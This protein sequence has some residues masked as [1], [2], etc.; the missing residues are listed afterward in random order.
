VTPASSTTAPPRFIA[1][2]LPQFHPIPEND[3]WW[4]KGF[5]EWTNVS[6]AK[7][8]F[9]GH[10]QPHVPSD[11][12]FYDLRVPEARE[13]QAALARQYGIHGFMYYHYWFG[14]KRLIERP[15]EEVLKTGQPDF[16]FCLCWANEPW[17]RSWLGDTR[18]ILMPQ[19]YSP[20]DF[21]RHAE[22]L[23]RAFADKRYIRVNGRP[24]FV[25]YRHSH[26]PRDYSGID[27]LRETLAKQGSP[28]PYLVAVDSHD[29]NFDYRTV[30]FDH[31][32]AF[33]PALGA[34]AGSLS[35]HPFSPRRVVRN[36]R[37]G[38]A[39]PSLKIYHY[40]EAMEMMERAAPSH[41]RIPC[42]LV[43]WDN[44]ARRGEKAVVFLESNPKTFGKVLERRL[45]QWAGS[46][47]STDLFFLNAW[48]EWAEGNHL[49]PDQKYGLGYLETLRKVRNRVGARHGWPEIASAAAS[50]PLPF[51][52]QDPALRAM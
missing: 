6:R 46:S 28:D 16:P 40:E 3:T 41:S 32:L 12:G 35:N 43:A 4:G 51:H 36:L 30:G 27:I 2:Y 15:F 37:A 49:E 13:A 25:I 21:R 24:L 23:G 1:H 19:E 18:E 34:V 48:N 22:W 26:M 5:T 10:Y 31:V 39:S 8:L 38:V 9:R 7:P 45:D 44:S 14:G 47:P 50:E 33:E 11:L 42:M 29:P 20:D 52:R 17:S